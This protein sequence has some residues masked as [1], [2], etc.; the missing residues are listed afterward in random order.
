MFHP[1]RTAEAAFVLASVGARLVD[2]PARMW[3]SAVAVCCMSAGL[4]VSCMGT[5]G[6]ATGWSLRVVGSSTASRDIDLVQDTVS[7]CKI[8]RYTPTQHPPHKAAYIPYEQEHGQSAYAPTLRESCTVLRPPNARS[9]LSPTRCFTAF[10]F[11][12]PMQIT[13]TQAPQSR[14]QVVLEAC[15]TQCTCNN[16]MY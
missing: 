5:G 6:S 10:G 14:S 3:R 7:P 11:E 15:K 9:C 1:T 4:L 2:K 16:R 13:Q 8:C 12:A